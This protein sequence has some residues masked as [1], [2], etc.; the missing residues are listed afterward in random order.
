MTSSATNR[1]PAS[2]HRFALPR[3]SR[4]EARNTPPAPITG[5][6]KNAATCSGPTSSIAAR[7][8]VGIV[9]GH[10][11]DVL[12]QRAVSGGVRRDARERGPGGVHPVVG[13]L[14]SHEDR[15]IRLVEELPVP[16]GHLGRGVDRVG[17][18]AREEH[19]GAADQGESRHSVGELERHRGHDVAEVRV[20][21]QRRHLRRRGLADL[22]TAPSDVAV[23]EG[24]RR[25]EVA[26]AVDVPDVAAVPSV[27]DE[28]ASR[29]DRGHVGERMPVGLRHVGDA[30]SSDARSED[31]RSSYPGS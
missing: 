20:G 19:L 7:S 13:L 28:L 24:R 16:A 23:P 26:G 3:G 21:R 10:L 6:Q 27:Q 5:S 31:P 18:T 9:P 30:T 1:T 4:Q 11:Q 25:I 29:G 14:P 8:E 12:D 15:A 2:R 22:G 17:P